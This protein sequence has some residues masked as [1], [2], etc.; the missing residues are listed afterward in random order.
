MS[1]PTCLR[2]LLGTGALTVGLAGPASAQPFDRAQLTHQ[3]AT[4]PLDPPGTIQPGRVYHLRVELT[5][6]ERETAARGP[7][8]APAYAIVSIGV[9]PGF[10]A[11][12]PH[13]M[14]YTSVTG[15]LWVPNAWSVRNYYPAAAA[16]G[17]VVVT[18]DGDH[19]PAEDTIAWRLAMTGVAL[20][21]TATLWPGSE[22]WP[23]A[24]GG[25]SG[26]SKLSFYTLAFAARAHRPVAGL[27]L[28]GCNE[29][30]FRDA[31]AMMQLDSRQFVDLPVFFSIGEHDRIVPPE[32]SQAAMLTL[33]RMGLRHVEAATH[34]GRH[35]LVTEHVRQAL[36]YFESNLL[37]NTNNR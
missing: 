33:Q 25:F 26:G 4:L 31:L 9:P 30:V 23:L 20:R 13:P 1:F 16:E 3:L 15:D 18:A 6:A 14:L 28:G 2:L 35:Q 19:W 7:N 12:R 10:V 8:Q 29:S 17:W 34:P 32:R 36:R 11:T 5:A 27:F 21:A 22:H 24:T 37:E